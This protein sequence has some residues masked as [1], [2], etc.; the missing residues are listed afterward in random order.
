MNALNYY[1]IAGLVVLFGLFKLVTMELNRRKNIKATIDSNLC[2]FVTAGGSAYC[3]VLKRSGNSVSNPKDNS[4]YFIDNTAVYNV[5][6]PENRPAF[7]QVTIGKV[8][9]D[10]GNPEPKMKRDPDKMIATAKSWYAMQREKFSEM[11]AQMS[12]ELGAGLDKM[13]A[14]NP[15]LVYVLLILAFVAA[16]VAAFMAYQSANTM[17]EELAIIKQAIG[18]K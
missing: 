6:Y 14:L 7:E 8:Y 1:I 4:L 5:K 12:R 9:Y 15:A 16:V 2:E 3:L 10:E 17:A 13:K 11:A 18:I